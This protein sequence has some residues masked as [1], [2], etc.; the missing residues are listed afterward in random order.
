MTSPPRAPLSAISSNAIIAPPA[1]S[2]AKKPVRAHP[3]LLLI[4]LPA[5]DGQCL[6]N[7]TTKR[8][9]PTEKPKYDIDDDICQNVT[10][11]C[12]AVRNKIRK[13][14]DSGEMKVGE[15]QKAIGASSST[16]SSFM[17][18]T[19]PMDGAG[20]SVYRNGFAFFK[21]RELNGENRKKKA[22]V[23]EQGQ[24]K[25]KKKE[26]EEEDFNGLLLEGEEEGEVP[27][28][29][30]CDEIRQKINH[31]LSKTGM[32]K[33]AFGREIGKLFGGEEEK[34]ITGG[35]VTQFLG[36]KGPM[37]GNT[38]RVYY[39]AYVF[40]EKI[41]VRDGKPMTEHRETM[42]DVWDGCD[43]RFWIKE[44]VDR[45]KVI[46]RMEYI[47][48]ADGPDLYQDEYGKPVTGW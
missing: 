40:F 43:L 28:F 29:D 30:S 45:S 7:T 17:R 37:A 9:A 18:K 5:S 21:L 41:R 8:K 35:S 13:F 22:K 44:G 32:S 20:S 46:D 47:T 10:I 31:Y 26:V 4:L 6:Q 25:E 27:I 1:A 11:S 48:F 14:L 24:V 38:T 15:F 36:K 3:L 33:A 19:G 39:G 2:A 12:N 42:E 16:Y 34:K 23:G